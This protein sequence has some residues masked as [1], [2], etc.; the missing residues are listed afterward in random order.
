MC[1]I[2]TARC[3]ASRAVLDIE[4]PPI[5]ADQM[6]HA[7]SDLLSLAL[8]DARNRTLRWASANEEALAR[9]RWG[10]GL[11]AEPQPCDPPLWALGHLGWYQEFWIARN[12][13]RL[14][15]ERADPGAARLASIDPAADACYDPRRAPFDVRWHLQPTDLDATRQ[16]LV[17]TL[18]TTLEL[19][20]HAG[21]ADDAL[22]FFRLALFHEDRQGEVLATLSQSLGLPAPWLPQQAIYPRRPPLSFPAATWQLGSPAG[23]FAFDNERPALPHQVPEFEIDSH[24]V[25]WDQYAEFVGDGGYDEPRWW[26][27]DGWAWVQQGQRRSPRHVDQLRHG[28]LV[29]RFGQAVRVPMDQAAMHLT[30]YEADAWC[31]WAGRRLPTEVEWELAAHQGASRGFRWGQVWEWTAGTC[32][33]YEGFVPGPDAAWSVPA[34]DGRH[35]ALRGASFATSGRMRHARFRHALTPDRD[36]HFTGFRSCAA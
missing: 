23:G 30:W 7:G 27:P 21:P 25:T 32:R 11:M 17:T 34:F 16:Y 33:P 3:G 5:P 22:Y 12:L 8:I 1:G 36:D 18:E 14:R 29:Q 19:L 26:T 13:Q 15:G 24:A 28:V 31:R 9:S 10:Q 4:A 35:K 2:D 6:R 20:E